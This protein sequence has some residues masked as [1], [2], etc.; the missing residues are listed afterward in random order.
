MWFLHVDPPWHI[1]FTPTEAELQVENPQEDAVGETQ[2]VVD[3]L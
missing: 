1:R 2:W 3:G